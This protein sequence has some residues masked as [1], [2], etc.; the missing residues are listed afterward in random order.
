MPT[1]VNV[2]LN[3]AIGLIVKATKQRSPEKIIKTLEEA[4]EK[5][6]VAI[7]NLKKEASDV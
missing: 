4:K 7:D 5:I 6:D 3:K 2:I 1:Y